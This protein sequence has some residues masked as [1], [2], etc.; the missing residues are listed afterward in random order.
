MTLQRPIT[1]PDRPPTERIADL[2]AIALGLSPMHPSD[3][4]AIRAEHDELVA[5]IEAEATAQRLVGRVECPRCFIENKACARHCE[6]AA[7]PDPAHRW[8]IN[9]TEWAWLRWAILALALLGI[10]VTA[11]L[12]VAGATGRLG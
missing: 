6:P 4:A 10:G 8:T 9:D 7:C 2:S 3:Y 12:A 5:A 1:N 11:A